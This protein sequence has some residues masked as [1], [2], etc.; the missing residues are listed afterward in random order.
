MRQQRQRAPPKVWLEQAVT[1]DWRARF[2]KALELILLYEAGNRNYPEGCVDRC[3]E[4]V[5]P[6]ELKNY[7]N[8]TEDSQQKETRHGPKNDQL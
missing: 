5:G 2:S 1:P 6:T 4:T 3:Q 7:T 8:A